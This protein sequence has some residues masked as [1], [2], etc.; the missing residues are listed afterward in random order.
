[1]S[2]FVVGDEIINSSV[3]AFRA[4]QDSSEIIANE[5]GLSLGIAEDAAKLAV[6]MF[7]LNCRAVAERYGEVE[8]ASLRDLKFHFREMRP[9]DVIQSYKSLRY[10]LYQCCEGKVPE[11]S[12]LY[13]TMERVCADMS[14]RIV[15][16]LPAYHRAN[17]RFAKLDREIKRNL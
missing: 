2:S 6:A 1:M 13:A 11:D 16:S 10:W 17:P 5:M 7:K 3:A 15:M 8:A 14:H 4:D 12:L 9:R